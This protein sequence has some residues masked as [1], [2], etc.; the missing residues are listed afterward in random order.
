MWF[1]KV[2]YIFAFLCIVFIPVQFN[3]CNLQQG[4]TDGLFGS[5]IRGL[6]NLLGIEIKNPSVSSDSAAM[7]LLM[8]VLLTLAAII[9]LALNFISTWKQKQ[10]IIFQILRTVFVYYLAVHLL[11]YGFDKVFKY[12]FYLPEPNTLYTTVGNLSKD[13]LYWTSMGTSYW[14]SVFAGTMEVLAALFLLFKKT[15]VVGLLLALGIML[16][17]M[18]INLGFDISVKLF[19][20]FLILLILILLQPQYKRLYD[21]LI[22]Q[23]QVHLKIQC[24]YTEF[25]K[26]DSIIPTLKTFIICLCLIESLLPYASARNFNDDTAER[27]HLHG[28]Y[29]ITEVININSE[30]QDNLSIKRFFVHR[31]GYIIFENDKD[32]MRDFKL[33]INQEKNQFEL[34]NY[35]GR[36]AGLAY[37]YNSKDSTMELQYFQHGN[38]YL[39][40]AKAINWRKLPALLDGFHLMVDSYE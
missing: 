38:E 37:S 29:E 26:N 4:V 12:Q 28:A 5:F 40:K 1:K 15:R 17:V 22:L 9:S 36:K 6:G 21:F 19:S 35:D 14:Y 2:V 11:K 16:N 24:A 39:L 13:I 23:K 7:Y 27:P 20:A 25:F 34:T 32:Q 31:N 3:L 18:A 33:I 30:E 8:L 10:N